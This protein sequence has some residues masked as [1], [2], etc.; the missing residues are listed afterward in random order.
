MSSKEE[1][2]MDPELDDVDPTL[3]A[4]LKKTL[5]KRG[6][7]GGMKAKIRAELYKV[8]DHSDDEPRSKTLSDRDFIMNELV[9]DYLLHCKLNYSL[10]VF[11]PESGQPEMFLGRSQLAKEFGIVETNAKF[12]NLPLLFTLISKVHPQGWDFFKLKD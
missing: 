2:S 8:I 4:A 5:E 9:R 12:K 3:A 7:L 6:A 10:S 11:T 1:A